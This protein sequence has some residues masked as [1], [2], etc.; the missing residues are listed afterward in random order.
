[1][2]EKLGGSISISLPPENVEETKQRTREVKPPKDGIEISASSSDKIGSCSPKASHSIDV[3]KG[4]PVPVTRTAMSAPV[5][6]DQ[7]ST[8]ESARERLDSNTCVVCPQKVDMEVLSLS[9]EIR[10][11]GLS[12]TQDVPTSFK[13]SIQNHEGSSTNGLK[14]ASK[15]PGSVLAAKEIVN[16]FSKK[17]TRK[18]S[19]KNPPKDPNQSCRANLGSMSNGVETLT[20]PR[21][22]GNVRNNFN[23]KYGSL[24]TFMKHW[25]K[26][27]RKENFKRVSRPEMV[28]KRCLKGNN[29]Q[30]NTMYFKSYYEKNHS[31]RMGNVANTA[32]NPLNNVPLKPKDENQKKQSEPSHCNKSHTNDGKSKDCQMQPIISQKDDK[33]IPEKKLQAEDIPSMPTESPNKPKSEEKIPLSNKKNK[34]DTYDSLE[35]LINDIDDTSLDVDMADPIEPEMAQ[36][37]RK[38]SNLEKTSKKNAAAYKTTVRV[39]KPKQ[40]GNTKTDDKPSLEPNPKSGLMSFSHDSGKPKPEAFRSLRIFNAEQKDPIE[41]DKSWIHSDEITLKS[42]KKPAPDT[43]DLKDNSINKPLEHKKNDKD[44][45]HPSQ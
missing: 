1:M 16:R 27:Y 10:T 30:K 9:T 26:A 34:S 39:F 21:R 4:S 8:F 41:G 43:K 3:S 45:L 5:L 6:E 35:D 14:L 25:R 32:N 17:M 42:L 44:P 31:K 19:Q 22:T 2:N 11:S 37:E 23:K 24:D 29:K 40:K 36:E 15:M 38:T 13:N 33:D 18:M 28:V 7:S 20:G 12:E